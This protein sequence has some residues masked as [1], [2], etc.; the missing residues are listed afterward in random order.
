[1][2]KFSVPAPTPTL[3]P[4][5]F[6]E[7]LVKSGVM[8]L[9]SEIGDKTFFI[10]AIMA[11]RHSRVT[12]RRGRTDPE[13]ASRRGFVSQG[14]HFVTSSD[15]VSLPRCVAF[16]PS[17]PTPPMVVDPP[18]LPQV[19]AGAIG[20]LGVMTALSA[21]MGW[22][23]PTLI[24]KVYTHYVAVALFL[25]FGA[26]SLYDSTI[27]WDGGGQADELREVEEELGD[28]TTGKDKGALLGWK[29][30]LTFGGLLSPIFLQTFF[31]TFVAEWGDRSQIATIGLAA[32]SDPYGVTRSARARPSSA[33]GT[34]RARCPN[35]RFPRAAACCSCCLACTR[36]T[37]GP[38]ERA[39]RTFAPLS[40]IR[41]ASL[42]SQLISRYY[43]IVVNL[44]RRRRTSRVL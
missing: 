23:A 5:E 16:S 30:T 3:D 29:K 22:A 44:S 4:R 36:S 17:V 37:S 18:R 35:A 10:A 12:V 38:S 24:S 25:F 7:G 40:A 19:F 13:P 32:S 26:R 6:M 2:P 41:V 27:A 20:A 34:W 1:M 33:G 9:L 42:R 21:A 31:I 8:I 39:N 11:M 43:R 28:E 14:A 15:V